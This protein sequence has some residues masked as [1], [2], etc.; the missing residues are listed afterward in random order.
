MRMNDDVDERGGQHHGAAE[1]GGLQQMRWS[2][3]PAAGSQCHGGEMWSDVDVATFDH[4]TAR[5]SLPVVVDVWL[6]IR[7]IPAMILFGR[8][9]VART[10]GAMTAGLIARWVRVRL[11]TVAD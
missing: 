6:G 2:Q 1:S 7:S 9:E 5:S 11:P 4:Q 10:S 3:P 8:R